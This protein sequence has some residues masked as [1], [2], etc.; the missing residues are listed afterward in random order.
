M[1]SYCNIPI[2]KEIQ[3]YRRI[4]WIK[5]SYEFILGSRDMPT[6]RPEALNIY[7]NDPKI[8]N[9]YTP[10]LNW[11]YKAHIISEILQQLVSTAEYLS[12]K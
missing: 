7:M 5:L 8:Q 2:N 6:R 3:S 11:I 10:V 4:L 12:D 9:K 1:L